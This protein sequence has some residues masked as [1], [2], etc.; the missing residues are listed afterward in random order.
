M[1]EKALAP[2]SLETPLDVANRLRPRFEA[3]KELYDQRRAAKTRK[4]YEWA[5][6]RFEK[7]CAQE[8]FPAHPVTDAV[9]ALYLADIATA[10]KSLS[11]ANISVAALAADGWKPSDQIRGILEGFT[12]ARA[13]KKQRKA[14]ISP[15]ELARMVAT[16]RTS[17]YRDVRNRAILLFG[18]FGAFRRGEICA[19]RVGDV[20]E[21]PEGLRIRV[22]RSKTDQEGKGTYV[23]ILRGKP[24]V[25]AVY[26]VA[27]WLKMAGGDRG[28]PL[29]CSLDARLIPQRNAFL[30]GGDIARIVKSAAKKAGLDPSRV[31]GHSLRSG[32]ATSAAL[33]KQPLEAIMRQTRHRDA[34]VLI[35]DYVRPASL[36][37]GNATAAFTELDTPPREPSAP[38]E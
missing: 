20:E 10:G 12:R 15:G 31:A 13:G 5:V 14:P 38:R 11:L 22:T 4:T 21:S 34:N 8:R 16:F 23:G 37:E 26:A 3:A 9:V 24:P 2:T 28:D 17:G 35:R 32:F 7:W 33:A 36:F 1:S 6:R 25:C 27:E 30:E 19:F 29:F 18:W